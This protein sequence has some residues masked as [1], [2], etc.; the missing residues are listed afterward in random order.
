[1]GMKHRSIIPPSSEVLHVETYSLS[2]SKGVC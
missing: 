2:L 1:M